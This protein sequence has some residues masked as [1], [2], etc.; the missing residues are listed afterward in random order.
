MRFISI[1]KFG[2]NPKHLISITIEL[3]TKWHCDE[4]T[5]LFVKV[6]KSKHL[7]S[8]RHI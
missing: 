7:K 3:T 1:D 5:V 2:L 6:I 4:C 8:K